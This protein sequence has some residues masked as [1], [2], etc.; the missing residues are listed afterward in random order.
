MTRVP[1]KIACPAIHVLLLLGILAYGLITKPTVS[2][3][4][5]SLRIAAI[6][7]DDVIS[8]FDLHSR[9]LLII[10]LSELPR[11]QQTVER[12]APQVLRLLIDEKLKLQ[13]ATRLGIEVTQADLDGALVMS[14]RRNKMT[15][16]RLVETLESQGIGV[17]T[18]LFQAK[19]EIAWSRIVPLKY[20]SN[21]EISVE[22]IAAEQAKAKELQNQPMFLLSEIV[23]PFD[24]PSKSQEVRQ[25]AQQLIKEMLN[26]AS[27]ASLARAFSEAPTANNGGAIDW[28]RLDQL[29]EAI[30]QIVRTMR[31][32][33]VST[34]ISI[35]GAYIIIN[36]RDI[37][38][39]S[40]EPQQSIVVDLNQFHLPLP[41]DASQE[42]VNSYMDT[43]ALRTRDTSD[44]EA[45]S[46]VAKQFGSPLSGRLGEI[47]LTKLPNELS[48]IVSGQRIGTPSPPIRTDDA[49]VVLMVCNRIEP[50]TPSDAAEKKKIERR[51]FGQRI[52]VYA[53][54][55]L[56]DLRRAAYIEVR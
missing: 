51:L 39:G 38:T 31:P 25:Q 36:L 40:S 16:E 23:L 15:P 33:Q 19:A 10:T 26:G 27:F 11:N 24:N 56:R 45:F 12:L 22:D 32:G 29:P 44:C 47:E 3:A 17:E 13:E 34:E 14:A 49:V 5:E 42:T 35:P 9:T 54:Q 7:N 53:R 55:A 28:I 41:S 4:Q 46:D 6:V 48:V 2:H 8:A 20:G 50:E 21:V 52:A 37:Q 18:L 30:A 1:F 43:A